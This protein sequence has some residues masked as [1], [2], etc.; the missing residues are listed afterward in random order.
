[1]ETVFPKRITV[2]DLKPYRHMN[3]P[4]TLY[5]PDTISV[6]EAAARL[7][8]FFEKVYYY[9]PAES[10]EN[11]R[12]KPDLLRELGLYQGLVP[13]PLGN[14]LDRFN[15][16]VRDLQTNLY[17]YGER[18]HHLAAASFA[19][20]K[21]PDHDEISVS[22]LIAAMSS[23]S[24][25][26]SKVGEPPSFDTRQHELWQARIVLKLAESYDREKEEIDA[27]LAK[28]AHFEQE[29]VSSLKGEDQDERFDEITL[30]G[31]V[32]GLHTKADPLRQRMRAWTSLYLADTHNEL[33]QAPDILSTSRRD[34]V[35]LLLEAY[36]ERTQQQ[37]EIL[38]SLP[39]PGR[40]S[41]EVETLAGNRDAFRFEVSEVLDYLQKLISDTATGK[42]PCS[43][44]VED[45]TLDRDRLAVWTDALRRHYPP[46]GNSQ[47]LLTVYCLENT[48]LADLMERTF[49]PSRQQRSVT[50]RPSTG[51]IAYLDIK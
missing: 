24:G 32:E 19:A 15:R 4:V 9:L 36:T 45:E 50:N 23:G 31:P 29:I 44:G 42:M 38:F 33:S 34:V 5:F 43:T 13:A 7:L 48:C 37:P 14:D 16:A 39:V 6:P 2:T 47:G 21:I 3:Q 49:L 27:R 10:G 1:M 40:S 20:G 11:G 25:A 8:L 22:S 51:L 30:P 26:G 18:L 12:G 35:A 17:E 41:L 46:K 28:L